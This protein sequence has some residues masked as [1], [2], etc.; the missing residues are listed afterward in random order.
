MLYDKESK[1]KILNLGNAITFLD[2]KS[3]EYNKNGDVHSAEIIDKVLFE[4]CDRVDASQENNNS[5]EKAENPPIDVNVTLQ[6]SLVNA[7]VT[8]QDSIVKSLSEIAIQ[9]QI[10][11]RYKMESHNYYVARS[12]AVEDF[13]NRT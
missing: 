7:D 2:E 6:K 13:Y 8:L 3:Q 5:E 1:K 10:M 11:N 4:L 9:L 12:M